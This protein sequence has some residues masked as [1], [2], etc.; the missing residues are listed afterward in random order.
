MIHFDE[1]EKELS[2]LIAEVNLDQE[3]SQTAKANIT[4]GIKASLHRIKKLN[5]KNTRGRR[6]GAK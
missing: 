3:I 1:I 6:Y 2:E 5:K 4:A